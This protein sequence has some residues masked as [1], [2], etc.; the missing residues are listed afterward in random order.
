M[1]PVTTAVWMSI[2]GGFTFDSEAADAWLGSD[3]CLFWHEAITDSV[4]KKITPAILGEFVLLVVIIFDVL[5][6]DVKNDEC[7]ERAKRLCGQIHQVCGNSIN[8]DESDINYD[9]NG[10][11]MGKFEL[12]M[13]LPEGFMNGARTPRKVEYFTVSN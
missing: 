10:E 2:C 4:A 11:A 7:Q 5:N 3:V 13:G 6:D 8:Y 1:F 12:E 9:A